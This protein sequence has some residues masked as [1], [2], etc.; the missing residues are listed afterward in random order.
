MLI[1]KVKIV[2]RLRLHESL[3]AWVLVWHH[4]MQSDLLVLEPKAFPPSVPAIALTLLEAR[5][6]ATI[7]IIYFSNL[8]VCI[9]CWLQS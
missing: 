6:D 4:G 2:M 5:F 9:V 7:P 8:E 3:P 1:S